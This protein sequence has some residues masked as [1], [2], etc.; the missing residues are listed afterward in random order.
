[1]DVLV[2]PDGTRVERALGQWSLSRPPTP[3][4]HVRCR[5][6]DLADCASVEVAT[7]VGLATLTPEQKG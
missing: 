5:S 7:C 2:A 3:H 1:V 6:Y 4:L